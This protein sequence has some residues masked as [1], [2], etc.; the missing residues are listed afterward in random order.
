[1]RLRDLLPS[2]LSHP[3][4]PEL[5]NEIGVLAPGESRKVKLTLTPTQPGKIVH[6]VALTADGVDRI[7]NKTTL[8]IED[9]RL[10][11]ESVGPKVRYLQRPCTVELK[12]HN[13]GSAPARQVQLTAAMPKGLSF[14]HA[15]DDGKHDPVQ[16]SVQWAIEIGRAHV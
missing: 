14:A 12:I 7:E 15:S 8:D 11:L 9:V 3:Q 13:Q 10:V 1:M 16:Q 6:A 4:G 5:E 2:G